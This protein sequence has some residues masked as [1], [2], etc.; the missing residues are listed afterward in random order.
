MILTKLIVMILIC[1][2]AVTILIAINTSPPKCKTIE[3]TTTVSGIPIPVQKQVC[4]SFFDD[5]FNNAN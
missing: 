4:R 1:N 3:V 2:L 5:W